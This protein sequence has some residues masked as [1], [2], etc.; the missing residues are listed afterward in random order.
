MNTDFHS[1]SS[2]WP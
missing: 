2:Q 1:I